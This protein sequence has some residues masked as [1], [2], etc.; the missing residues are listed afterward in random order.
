[1]IKE[2]AIIIT[3]ASSGVG[4]ATAMLLASYGAN[5]TV[6]GFTVGPAYQPW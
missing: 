6:S 5:T 3:G 1:M 2:K 4:E